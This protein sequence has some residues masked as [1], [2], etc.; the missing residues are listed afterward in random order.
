[1]FEEG[2]DKQAIDGKEVDLSRVGIQGPEFLASI[3][4]R[5]G[6]A[7]DLGDADDLAGMW[8]AVDRV[9]LR[10]MQPGPL[11]RV[12]PTSSVPGDTA[13]LPACKRWET[14]DSEIAIPAGNHDRVPKRNTQGTR[15]LR[16]RKIVDRH[17][18]IGDV[19]RC[20]LQTVGGVEGQTAVLV[21]PAGLARCKGHLVRL[22]LPVAIQVGPGEEQR[23]L[24]G[25]RAVMGPLKVEWRVQIDSGRNQTLEGVTLK[26]VPVIGLAD[27][28]HG[29]RHSVFHQPDTGNERSH[30]RTPVVG[31][32]HVLASIQIN[33]RLRVCA[34]FTMVVGEEEI[35]RVVAA[36]E[37]ALDPVCALF[38]IQFK[39]HPEVVET[40]FVLRVEF[41]A[42]AILGWA[43]EGLLE[44]AVFV[45][46][47][48]P[49][50]LVILLGHPELAGRSEGQSHRVVHFAFIVGTT[51]WLAGFSDDTKKGA[52]GCEDLHLMAVSVVRDVDR[53]IGSDH[54]LLRVVQ[55]VQGGLP[56][57][58]KRY[59]ATGRTPCS[60][61]AAP[62]VLGSLRNK[63]LLVLD[64]ND[65][66]GIP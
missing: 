60:G 63:R 25:G 66:L 59:G 26:D 16:L 21:Q 35:G 2:G 10:R 9:A 1:M 39:L 28:R 22:D 37:D 3:R 27:G 4:Y 47:T 36:E 64:V 6:R 38:P 8:C 50:G 31:A 12:G 23:I 11:A 33:R 41:S 15:P 58:R 5:E 40:G 62:A 44:A 13:D 7:D 32:G 42:S 49:L 57:S 45:P 61:C 24:V 30:V 18:T 54:D 55:T 65:F 46:D 48:H 56:P 53:A 14:A 51:G 17:T 43:V 20:D 52:I 29:L 19:L 34:Q